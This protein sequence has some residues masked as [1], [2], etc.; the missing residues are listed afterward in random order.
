MHASGSLSVLVVR[1]LKVALEKEGAR[2]AGL[3]AE[4]GIARE[5]L[6]QSDARLP[7]ALVF[8]AIERAAEL[9]GDPCF[10]L[11][12]ANAVP[13]GTIDV[14]DFAMRTSATMREALG[15]AT[16]YYSLIDD[17]SE[18]RLEAEG[19]VAR[20]VCH[21]HL[22]A[23]PLCATE[24]L[25]AML[26]TRGRQLTG[27]PWPLR[28][29]CFRRGSAETSAE[30]EEFFGAKV[31][32]ARE[33]NEI[34][35]DESWL[36][37]PCIAHDP[38]LGT[39]LDGQAERMLERLSG[40][41]ELL[42]QAKQAIAVSIRGSD[43]ALAKTA[44]R[45]SLSARTLQRRLEAAGTSHSALVEEV[46]R[47]LTMTFFA[48]PKLTVLEVGY[49]VGFRDVSTFYRAFKRWTGSTPSIARR[50]LSA[51]D[52]AALARAPESSREAFKSSGRGP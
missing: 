28:E 19:G 33:R 52:D 41:S 1:A 13:L 23:S 39:F 25:F 43:P 31:R 17:V 18:L 27:R 40:S 22:D 11:H 2:G 30:H 7:A 36:E 16:R 26:F 51:R 12:A 38:A 42:R 9:T 46:R 3:L 29:V 35:F 32:F 15:R 24:L 47:E 48:N 6:D 34:V 4:L 49:L 5:L 8:S 44:K 14:V 50:A 20:L 45:L 37:T 10:S 21:R